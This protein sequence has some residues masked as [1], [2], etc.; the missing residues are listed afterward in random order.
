MLV[1]D[2]G[3]FVTQRTEPRLTHR[4]ERRGLRWPCRRRDTG[5]GG[6][7]ARRSRDRAGASV[8]GTTKSMRSTPGRTSRTGSEGFSRRRCRWCSCRRRP[9]VRYDQVRPPR[10]RR[11]VCRRLPAAL[12]Q[13][14]LARRSQRPAA[15][16]LP[17][18]RFRPNIVVEGTVPWAEDGWTRLRVSSSRSA[19]SRLAIVARSPPSTSSAGRGASGHWPRS[20]S[21]TGR[22][23]SASTQ[24][25]TR[26]GRSAWG[27]RS[28][29]RTEGRGMRCR[30]DRHEGHRSAPHER[31]RRPL[32]R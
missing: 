28:R 22:C 2:H 24:S 18:N 21:A 8:S 19:S 12:H 6:S 15:P 29:C 16:T 1:D 23:I 7:N 27:T 26:R 25:R 13:H 32:R 11:L 30:H 10:R 31:S 17:M 5:R 4:G 20:A 14:L 9:L 3:D